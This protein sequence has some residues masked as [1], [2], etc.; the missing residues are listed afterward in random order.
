MALRMGEMMVVVRAQDFAS[1]TL[2]RVSG[3]LAGMSRQQMLSRQQMMIGARQGQQMARLATQGTRMGQL[4]MIQEQIAAEKE[5]SRV[6]TRLATMGPAPGWT[7]GG[8]NLLAQERALTTAIN[9]RGNAIGKMPANVQ[10]LA[11][12]E[13]A[14]GNAMAT[15]TANMKASGVAL[16]AG[17]DDLT[18]LN[19]AAKMLPMQRLHDFGAALS[20]IGRTMQLFGAVGAA[21]FGIMANSAAKFS[22][23]A[24]TAAT[25]MRDLGGSTA[26]IIQRSKILQ[27]A[28]LDMSMQF[29]ASA[30]DMTK[31]AYDIFSSMNLMHNGVMNVRGGLKLLAIANKAAVAGQV[32]LADATNA[33]VV[34]LNTFDPNLR[35]VQGTMDTVFNTVRFGKLRLDD[36]S[37]AFTS[38]SAVAKASGL[39]LKSVGGAFASLTLFMTS[40]RAAAGLGRLIEIFRN[41]V[42]VKG[43]HNMGI[44]VE[45]ASGQLR[46]LVDIMRDIGRLRPDLMKGQTS[47]LQFFIQ[48]S[49]ASGMTKAGIQ[50]T[51]Q[52]R[53]AFEQLITHLATFNEVS[54]EVARNKNELDKAFSAR[55][56]DPGVQWEIFKNQMR[57]L[58]IVIGREALPVFIKLGG[59]I[60]AGIQ[61]F[62][63]LN[64]G[65]SGTIIKIAA[66]ASLAALA[67]GVMLSMAGAVTQVIANL[68]LLRIAAA[69]TRTEFK[70]LR[71]AMITTGWGAI[72][73]GS[74][75]AAEQIMTH[76]DQVR[77]YFKAWQMDVGAGFHN[78]W[79]TILGDFEHGAGTIVRI[80]G[81]ITGAPQVENWGK[82]LQGHANDL[83]NNV[84]TF[85]RNYNAALKKFRAQHKK[86]DPL[87][88]DW[89]KRVN[90]IAA[91]LT[92]AEFRKAWE[93]WANTIGKSTGEAAQMAEA[94]ANAIKQATEN[95]TNTVKQATDNLMNTY[96]QL[97][98]QNQQALGG[99]FQG[100]TMQGIMGNVF[101]SI[102]DTLRQFGI[103]IPVPFQIL[104]QDLDQSVTYFKR[105]RQDI[106][107]LLKRGAP[108]EFVMQIQ[109]LGPQAGIPIA[110]GLLAGGKKGFQNLIKQWRSGQKLLDQATKQD[111]NR[112]LKYWNSFGKD[113]AWATITGLIDN[114]KN[115]AIQKMY[116][117]YVK[118][119]YGDI[120]KDQFQK[121]VAAALEASKRQIAAAKLQPKILPPPTTTGTGGRGQ[122]GKTPT[123]TSQQLLVMAARA[124]AQAAATMTAITKTKMEIGL[125]PPGPSPLRTMDEQRLR[126]LQRRRTRLIELASIE[127]QM[128]RG[129]QR[130]SYTYGDNITVTV[131]A[132]GAT[133]AAVL[134]ALNKAHFRQKHRKK[135]RTGKP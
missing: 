21:A 69:T 5:L 13:V 119:T 48:V 63:N 124:Q 55:L 45:K 89:L 122:G 123:Y 130:I 1:R 79:N 4:R 2:H 52:A 77:A 47:A 104:R 76:W 10:R 135:T 121:D 11:A 23:S 34:A 24:S 80:M 44:E 33:M 22:A 110:E 12:D 30:E 72:I 68:A 118:T 64:S 83:I 81:K 3:E 108:P 40:D 128:A 6:R 28:I 29:P 87:N 82:D 105:W 73:V 66:W 134:R 58:V 26:Q 93:D 75:V 62:R 39:S 19:N 96:Q 107:K 74:A 94:H 42:F 37:R 43:F 38:F 90:K 85:T 125:L 126:R 78:L 14:L 27:R 97:Y 32:D 41:P 127:R 99:L 102:N 114:P 101:G 116:R 61:W 20:G 53:R 25:Q 57:A 106:N 65:L 9:A 88:M 31:A 17:A 16:R 70:L 95:M 15:T 67:A 98:Q 50:G 35:D 59:W 86:D 111:M 100:P 36:L 54:G 131:K 117:D 18:H 112:K 92:S 84:D 115:L 51:V 7:T 49:K 113:A 129:Q 91:G 120:L 60:A 133:P 132:D 8:R 109:E 71:T 56:A 46:P 103:Q